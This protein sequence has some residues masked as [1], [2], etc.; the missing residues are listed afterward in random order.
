MLLAERYLQTQRGLDTE[1]SSLQTLLLT[2]CTSLLSLYT[3]IITSFTPPATASPL[4]C[5]SQKE[6]SCCL[7]QGDT[8]AP[9][10]FLFKHIQTQQRSKACSSEVSGTERLCIFCSLPACCGQ[11]CITSTEQ[12]TDHKAKENQ[13]AAPKAAVY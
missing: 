3:H 5:Y 13:S 9:V 11:L 10:S 8:E 6:K 1:P 4:L 7:R 2:L 12:Q